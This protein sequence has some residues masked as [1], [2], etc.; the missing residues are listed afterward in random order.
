MRSPG[1]YLLLFFVALVVILFIQIQI[2]SLVL[3]KLGLS[4][5]SAALLLITTLLGSAVNLPLARVKAEKPPEPPPQPPAYWPFKL[6]PFTGYT[7]IAI[8]VGGAMVPILFSLY[9][10]LSQ[11]LPL[12]SVL[13]AIGIVSA[14]SYGFSRPVAGLGIGMPIFIAPLTAAVVALLLAPEHSPPLAYICGTLGVL[15]GADLLRLKDI[16]KLGAP[17]A[18]IGGAGT[19][20]GIFFTG[21]IAVLLA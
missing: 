4:P 6:P 9:L 5:H 21:I 19:F 8:N 3:S 1:N 16:P 12:P 15:I 17:L 20:D 18:S 14:I 13:L 2:F 7:V 11:P 10:F